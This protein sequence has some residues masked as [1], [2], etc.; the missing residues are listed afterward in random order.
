MIKWESLQL[1]SNWLLFFF[2]ISFHLW[3]GKAL[4]FKA[5]YVFMHGTHLVGVR[6]CQQSTA[7]SDNIY[8]DIQLAVT[9]S[10]MGCMQL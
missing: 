10:S 9:V 4:K 6:M 7:Y 2:C 1:L 5:E 8:V 3:E